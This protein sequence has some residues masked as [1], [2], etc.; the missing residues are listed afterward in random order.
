MS[1]VKDLPW[2]KEAYKHIGLKEIP[3][4]EHNKTIQNWLRELKAWWDDD[5]TPWCG[6]AVA[7]CVKTANL[8]YPKM[9]MRALAWN[10]YGVELKE[11]KPGC[12][13][14]FTRSGGG[15]VGFVVGTAANGDLV[16]LGGNQGNAMSLAK[17]P[18][19]RVSSYR[20]PAGY[21][22]PGSDVQLQVIN[23]ISTSVSEA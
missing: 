4:K 3:G 23:N 15:H 12:I 1:N 10:E 7:H 11:P 18:K 9:Y 22:L 2:I 14:T 19:S 17:F 6:V 5:E 13:V 16:V 8:T 21:P 20:W